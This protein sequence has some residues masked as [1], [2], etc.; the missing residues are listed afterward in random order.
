MTFAE[1]VRLVRA[2]LALLFVATSL[3]L[4]GAYLMLARQPEQYAATATGYL[5]TG[6]ARTLE[7]VARRQQSVLGQGQTLAALA[8]TAPLADDVRRALGP[9]ADFTS[10]SAAVPVTGMIEVRAVALDPDDARRAAD[11]A[12]RRLVPVAGGLDSLGRP[13]GE[14]VGDTVV[15]T[16]IQDAVAPAAPFAPTYLRPLL[17]GSA[18][19]FAVGFAIALL[20]RALDARLRTAADVENAL[21]TGVLGVVP[22]DEGVAS[23]GPPAQEAATEALRVLRTHLRYLR[24]DDPP[25]SIVVTSPGGGEGRTSVAVQ[26]ARLVAATGEPVVLVEGDL[27]RPVLAAR[28]GLPG[29][30]GLC[31]V[32]AGE[33][34]LAE[35]LQDAG[36]GMR[37]LPAG[38]VPP[39]PTAILGTDR[40]QELLDR[41]GR[42]ALVVVDAP[43]L[44]PV[45]DAGLLAA[46]ADGVLLVARYGRTQAA[47]ASYCVRVLDQVGARLLGA[48]LDEVPVRHLGRVRQDARTTRRVEVSGA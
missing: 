31:Q 17:L 41:L 27:R 39:D 1:I 46:R 30:V 6:G 34:A 14:P 20:R 2:H 3:G 13:E 35:A 21:G 4:A 18:L 47:A 43:A 33:V 40:M 7:E 25:R 48:V 24:V 44:L 37:V 5:S 22:I 36:D 11:T 28:L 32:L 45:T 19:G 8:G 26:L 23:A 15:L 29:E 38:R 12:L 42:T 9:D 16:P 10:L